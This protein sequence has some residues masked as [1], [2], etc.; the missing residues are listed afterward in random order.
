MPFSSIYYEASGARIESL[1]VEQAFEIPKIFAIL[2]IGYSASILIFSFY[3]ASF[4]YLVG[5]TI[6]KKMIGLEVVGKS[7][8]LSLW[9]AIVRNMSKTVLFNL[10]PFD[11]FLMIFDPYKRRV[12]DFI[13][14]TLVVSNRKIIKKFG[15][16]NEL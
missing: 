14:S 16:V 11:C 4:E 6:G 12:S 8:K 1:T 15:A 9:Q 10:L 13:A 7:N 2:I 5:W 3:L